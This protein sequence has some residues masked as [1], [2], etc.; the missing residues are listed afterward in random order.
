M[1]LLEHKPRSPSAKSPQG[2][3]HRSAP[4][5]GHFL[6]LGYMIRMMSLQILPIMPLPKASV[7]QHSVF[8]W[9]LCKPEASEC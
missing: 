8:R 6:M 4:E 1:E 2:F 9:V 5:S 7:F 3:W